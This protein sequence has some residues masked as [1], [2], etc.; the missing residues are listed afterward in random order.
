MNSDSDSST[1]DYGD[2]LPPDIVEAVKE[3]AMDSLPTKSKRQY[4]AAYNAFKKWRT[5]KKTSSFLEEVFVAYFKELSEKHAPPTLWTQY[6]M[7]KTCVKNFD[8]IDLAKYNVLIS[9]IK[10]KNARYKKKKAKIFEP[11]EIRKFINEAPNEVYLCK[12]VNY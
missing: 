11:N 6:S 1:T 9:F 7:I 4:T 5:E 8:H 10:K 3:V 12:K 2:E